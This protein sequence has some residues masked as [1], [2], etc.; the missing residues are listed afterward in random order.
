[1]R[2]LYIPAALLAG[3]FALSLLNS[4]YVDKRT[5]QWL[6]ILEQVDIAADGEDWDR[7]GALAEE[8]Y[9]SWQEE[10]F[11][12]HTVVHHDG[13]DAAETLFL[14]LL[15]VCDE[16]DAAEARLHLAELR[17][18]LRLLAEKEQLSIPNIL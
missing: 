12:F 4:R 16:E 10:Q 15:V 8:V 17:S 6:Q 3:L 9:G 1:M 14:Q 7:A 11:Y 13:L 5:D 18:Q 2:A